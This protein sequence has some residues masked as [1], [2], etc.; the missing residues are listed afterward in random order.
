MV[1]LEVQDLHSIIPSEYLSVSGGVAHPLSYQMARAYHLP[2]RGHGVYVAYG[3]YMFSRCHLRWPCIITKIG[4]RSTPDL[5]T[6]QAV[7]EE[8][9][10]GSRTAVHYFLPTDGTTHMAIF[11]MDRK[12]YPMGRYCRRAGS[13]WQGADGAGGFGGAWTY[14]PARV[15]APPAHRR[16]GGLCKKRKA[17]AAMTTSGGLQEA[18]VVVKCDVPFIIDGLSVRQYAGLGIIFDVGAGQ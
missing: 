8:L 1:S 17:S 16:L 3:G 5:D 10:D 4:S 18:L 7:L 12:W 9:V 2:V 11:T 14:T 6:L 13:G 15:P